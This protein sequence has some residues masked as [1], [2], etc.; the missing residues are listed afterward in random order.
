MWSV[1]VLTR[2][3]ALEMRILS[4]LQNFMMQ[5]RFF[6][7]FVENRLVRA[8]VILVSSCT[9]EKY[10]YLHFK[11]FLK[12]KINIVFYAIL[13]RKASLQ[14]PNTFCSFQHLQASQFVHMVSKQQERP[15]RIVC[16]FSFHCENQLA[17]LL[18]VNQKALAPMVSFI[19]SNKSRA[20]LNMASLCGRRIM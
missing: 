11:L 5:K 2:M 16:I 14:V 18:K 13:K 6:D 9:D 17:L 20:K 10:S 1:N 19:V 7:D 15:P 12:A 4:L 8:C 3:G